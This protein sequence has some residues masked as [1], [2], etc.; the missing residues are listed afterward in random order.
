MQKN[1]KFKFS[2][3]LFILHKVI[4]FDPFISVMYNDS[5]NKQ[6]KVRLLE[7]F[8]WFYLLCQFIRQAIC[9]KILSEIDFPQKKS[10]VTTK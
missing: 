5:A 3:H 4:N 10:A 1:V 2:V 9:L 8:H 6:G 7:Q